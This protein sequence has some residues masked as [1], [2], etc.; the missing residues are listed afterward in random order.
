M[1]KLL[2]TSVNDYRFLKMTV[3]EKSFK[4]KFVV[5][6][7]IT[8]TILAEDAMVSLYFEDSRVMTAEE[9]ADFKS[10]KF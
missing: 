2:I 4:E 10:G 1:E 7:E 5:S 3:S 8:A 6:S 9:L